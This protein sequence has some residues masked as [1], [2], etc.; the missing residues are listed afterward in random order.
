MTLAARNI[1]VEIGGEAIRLRSTL[2]A[3]M[4]LEAEHG[5]DNL[6]RLLSQGS[7]TATTAILAEHVHSVPA[8]TVADVIG[9]APKLADHLAQMLDTGP[10][11]KGKGK[12]SGKPVTLAEQ[13]E[14]LYRLGTGHLGWTPADTWASSPAEILAAHSGRVDLIE[15]IIRAVWGTG[16]TDDAE[17]QSEPNF[18][19]DPDRRAKLMALKR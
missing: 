11:P 6:F 5:F 2:R 16:E 3:A 1:T 18:K 12:P 4:R 15:Q 13:F 7:M 10:Q 8:L 9:L 14:H 17:A 19:A